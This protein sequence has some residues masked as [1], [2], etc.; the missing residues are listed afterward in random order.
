MRMIV[1][2]AGDPRSVA[3]AVESQMYAVDRSQP[4]FDVKTMEERVSAAL[5][6]ERFQ[7]A[8]IGIF[9]GIAIVLAALGVYGVM[10]HLVTRRTRE[11]GIRIAVGAQPAQVQGLVLVETAVLA[12]AA[13]VAGLG[14]AWGL[15]RYL[16]TMLYGV[17]ALDAT[18][19]VAA[20]AMLIGVALAASLI[21]ARRAARIDPMTALREE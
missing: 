10:A 11:I 1:R 14:G 9:A 7:L 18:T 20:P 5:A 16:K 3:R 4:V 19:F 6:P 12:V 21:P 17:T 13:A 15:T 2:T 8:L